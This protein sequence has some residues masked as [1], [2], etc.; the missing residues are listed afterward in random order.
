MCYP[1]LQY[2]KDHVGPLAQNFTEQMCQCSQTHCHGHGR[3]MP[4]YAS[5]MYSD[6]CM[7]IYTCVRAC[8]CSVLGKEGAHAAIPLCR[9]HLGVYVHVYIP[10]VTCQYIP[11]IAGTLIWHFGR[12]F[13]QIYIPHLRTMPP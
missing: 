6:M 2:V 13:G 11:Y 9:P 3:C 4:R 5:C 12:L 8:V 1:L 10:R 7:Y